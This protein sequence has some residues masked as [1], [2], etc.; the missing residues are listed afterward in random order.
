VVLPRAG[1]VTEN[2]EARHDV[3]G[4]RSRGSVRDKPAA[5]AGAGASWVRTA[6]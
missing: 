6:S 5:Q 1:A 4:L 2:M 3:P